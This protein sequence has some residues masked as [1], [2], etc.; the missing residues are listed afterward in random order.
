[1]DI[2]A[3]IFATFSIFRIFRPRLPLEICASSKFQPPTTPASPG[4]Q[5]NVEKPKQKN[6][7]LWAVIYDHVIDQKFERK[8]EFQHRKIKCWGLS[9]TRFGRVS[10]QLELSSGVKRPI[11]VCERIVKNSY[12]RRQKMKCRGSSE[13]RFGKVSDRKEP[14]LRENRP[15]EFSKNFRIRKIGSLTIANGGYVGQKTVSSSKGMLSA[16]CACDYTKF[17]WWFTIKISQFSLISLLKP[18][19]LSFEN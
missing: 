13:T 10:S 6:C 5:K 4:G 7:K 2:F 15:F 8:F 14:C 18:T 11:K 16:A 1:M 3:N 17:P 9:E 12:F 19:T